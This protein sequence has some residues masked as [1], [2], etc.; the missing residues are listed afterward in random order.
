MFT[1]W[2][3][4]TS[5]AQALSENNYQ[6]KAITPIIQEVDKLASIG[7]RLTDLVARQGTLDDQEIASIQK[8]LDKAAEIHDEVVIAAVYPVEK[9][10][11]ATRNQ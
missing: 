6:L 7:L 1:R 3:S 2:Q 11:R 4:N 9:L 5:D 10:L 8:E